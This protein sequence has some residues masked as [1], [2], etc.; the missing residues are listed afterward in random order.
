MS[1]HFAPVALGVA[2][3]ALFPALPARAG[4]GSHSV[5]IDEDPAATGCSAMHVRFSGRT[6]AHAEETLTLSRAGANG[7]VFSGSAQGGVT[8]WGSDSSTFTITACKFGAGDDDAAAGAV[9]AKVALRQSGGRVTVEGPADEDWA[10]FLLVSAPRDA[11][12][13]VE[14]TNG[15]V[16]ARELSGTVSVRTANG[17]VSLTGLSGTLDV[18]AVNGPITLRQS[19]GDVRIK[20]A[21]GPLTVILAGTRWEGKGLQADAENGPLTIKVPDDYA[22]AV[23]VEASSHSPVSCRAAGCEKA[24]R[25]EGDSSRLVE[26]GG[27][28]A[29]VRLSTV[30]GPVSIVPTAGKS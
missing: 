26:I 16:S 28:N 4:H 24:H 9:L 17:P 14:A 2:A 13:S 22:S 25:E 3:L 15:P 20:A 8:V 27:S 12:L 10:G 19:S 1:R 7:L 18:D 5:S 21:N 30:N 23:R 6:S 11:D 29:V